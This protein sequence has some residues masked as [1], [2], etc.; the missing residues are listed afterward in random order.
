VVPEHLKLVRTPNGHIQI[1]PETHS[2]SHPKIFAGGDLVGDEQTVTDA[3]AAGLRAAWGI[4][5]SLRGKARADR[6]SPPR[7]VPADAEE[8]GPLPIPA[9][10]RTGRIAS[11]ELPPE[12][13]RENFEEVV[14][15]L[16]ETEARSEAARCL[17]CGQCGNCRAC[18]E[19]FGCPA[20]QEDEERRIFIDPTLCTG[21]GVCAELCPNG[22]FKVIT[23]VG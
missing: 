3:M 4:D 6:K 16:S 20:I 15:T 12:T 11:E 10:S 2:T 14:K 17:M 8:M 22:A 9:W 5:V 23:Y 19:L 13:R 18:V 7:P 21:C 1:D